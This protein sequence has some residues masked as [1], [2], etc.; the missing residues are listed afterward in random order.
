MQQHEPIWI[1]GN[2]QFE[3]LVRENMWRGD[4]TKNNPYIIENLMIY[5]GDMINCIR[6][7]D[8][9]VYFVIKNCLLVGTRKIY[10]TNESN[11]FLKHVT[12]GIIINN[13]CLISFCGILL[14]GSTNNII[15]NNTYIGDEGNGIDL[16]SNSLNNILINNTCITN[17]AFGIFLTS[18]N[19]ILSNN[20]C[21]AN[22]GGIYLTSSKAQN[23]IIM[24]N[25]F[26][27]NKEY[28][29]LIDKD[30]SN[31][32]VFNNISQYENKIRNEMTI[33]RKLINTKR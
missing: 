19:N 17:D 31:N 25:T 23:N 27:S 3:K 33:I 9:D 22:R 24:N 5:S 26:I 10:V 18:S 11:I 15:M 16:W 30:S 28:G 4:G 13:T 21:I 20:R 12:N 1:E 32:I 8:V 7:Q 2:Y 14:E 6:I 29:I